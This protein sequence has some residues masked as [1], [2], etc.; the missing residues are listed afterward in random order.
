MHEN[1]GVFNRGKSLDIE[2]DRFVIMDVT[3]WGESAPITNMLLF[4]I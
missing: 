4:H 2:E 3:I 1:L